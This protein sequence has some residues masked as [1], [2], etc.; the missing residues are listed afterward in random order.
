[1]CHDSRA[2]TL[3]RAAEI[4]AVV[5][6][7]VVGISHVV[8]PRVWVEFF[9][10]LRER[11]HVGVFLNGMLSLLVGSIIVAFHNVW[12]G[13]PM[14]VTLI[15]WAQVLKG[16]MSLVF[17]A[18]GLKGLMRVSMERAWEIQAGGAMFLVLCAVI[19]W[20]WLPR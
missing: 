14:I 15:G 9:A 16:L 17:P 1:M 7:A 4:F 8:R 6:F 20:S 5:N 3:E 2:M 12:A 10:L 13:V 19:A 18:A 11:G